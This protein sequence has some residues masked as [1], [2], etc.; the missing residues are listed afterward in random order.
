M[1]VQ[2]AGL[3]KT[4]LVKA[5]RTGIPHCD[6]GLQSIDSGGICLGQ[7]L[8]GTGLQHP[9]LHEGL[10]SSQDFDQG[11]IG[12]G[13]FN[14]AFCLALLAVESCVCFLALAVVWNFLLVKHPLICFKTASM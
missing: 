8:V 1:L 10:R 3:E 14:K 4:S 9:V 11:A 7:F 6:L 5:E 13:H 2:G 12:L